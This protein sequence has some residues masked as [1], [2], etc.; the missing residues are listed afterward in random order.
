MFER[1]AFHIPADNEALL[2]KLNN[3]VIE[4]LSKKSYATWLW[5]KFSRSGNSRSYGTRKFIAILATGLYP[6]TYQYSSELHIIFSISMSALSFHLCI[7]HQCNIS[8]NFLRRKVFVLFSVLP[9]VLYVPTY[10]ILLDLIK[11]KMQAMVKNSNCHVPYYVSLSCALLLSLSPKFHSN[12][13]Q[14][15]LNSAVFY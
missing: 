2:T 14:N 6:E 8:L 10:R 4:A 11:Q 3:N 9:F 12:F 7:G 1:Y 13:F 5:G 15:I